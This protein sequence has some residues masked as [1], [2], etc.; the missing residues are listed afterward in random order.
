MSKLIALA[1]ILLIGCFCAEELKMTH[2]VRTPMEA[3]MFIDYMNKGPLVK[4]IL[5][6]LQ[7]LYPLREAPNLYSYPEVKI[8]NYLDAQYYG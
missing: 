4:N 7:N 8:Y 1:A 6:I 2:R 5:K 3:K